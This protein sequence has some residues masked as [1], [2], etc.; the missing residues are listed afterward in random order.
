MTISH[1]KDK[2]GLALFD[3]GAFLDKTQSPEGKGFKLKLHDKN[4]EAPL[5]PFYLNFRKPDNPKPGPL[6]P[7]IIAEIGRSLYGETRRKNLR[8]DIIAG[9][10]RAGD[11][12]AEAFAE[13]HFSRRASQLPIL[14]LGKRESKK[15]RQVTEIVGGKYDQGAIVLLVDDLITKA[16]SKLEAIEVLE[17]AGLA[18]HD[19]LVLVDREQGG[20]Q[21]LKERGY[22]LHAVFGFSELLDLYLARG[23]INQ[24]LFDE[25]T[26][27]LAVNS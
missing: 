20:V 17:N 18:V 2:V 21:E 10:P 15:G 6:T 11:P 13:T 8:Y 5:S 22:S 14:K 19:V 7:E 26:A 16:G 1:A 3:I 12:L 27:Y 23:R 25:I 24:A 9:V 4:P